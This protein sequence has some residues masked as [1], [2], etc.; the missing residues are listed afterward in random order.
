ELALLLTGLGAAAMVVVVLGV[1]II[2][3]SVAR[4]LSQITTTIKRVAEGDD[5]VEVPH[6]ER[7]DEIGALARA[8]KV[9]QEA[10]DR[11]RSLNAQVLQDSEARD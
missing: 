6:A 7:G 10:M 5:H 3:R 2:A 11:N 9:F 1:L 8:I 4:P